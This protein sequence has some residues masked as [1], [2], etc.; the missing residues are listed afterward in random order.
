MPL[1]PAFN[2]EVGLSEFEASMVYRVSVQPGMYRETL[3]EKKQTVLTEG[4]SVVCIFRRD[5]VI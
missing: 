4:S 1:I 2:W 3:S 5:L